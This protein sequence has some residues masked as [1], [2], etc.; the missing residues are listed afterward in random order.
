MQIVLAVLAVPWF[1]HA[2]LSADTAQLSLTRLVG[3]VY[4]AEDPYYSKENSIV[5]IG[6]GHVTIVGA[7]WTPDTAKILALEIAKV[8]DKPVREVINTNYHP[9]RVGGN[10]YW[11]SIGAK[12]IATQQTYDLLK[13]DWSNVLA[14]TRNAFP[15]YPDVPLALPTDVYPG[16]FALQGG[17]VKAIYLGRS[18]TSDGIFVYFPEEKVLYGG[19]IL[20]EQL[21]NL[22]FA[23]VAEYPKTL[24][25]LQQLKLDIRTIVAGHYS[26]VH[27]PELID[28]YLTLLKNSPA[29]ATQPG[30]APK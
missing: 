13:K 30:T 8:T 18:H 16:D 14:W 10:A 27:G 4:I 9:D 23:D 20:K 21:G 28:Q 24:R 19:C 5:Y 22:A 11:K 15:S 26:P 6:P 25:K 29:A 1:Q 3:P 17:K 2:A 12:I 7:T